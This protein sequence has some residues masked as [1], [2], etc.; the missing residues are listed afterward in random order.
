[1]EQQLA[2][3]YKISEAVIFADRLDKEY[4]VTNYVGELSFFEDLERPY[5]T[6]QVVCMDDF[7]VFDE[8]KLMGSEQIRFTV[9][10]VEESVA[11]LS[12]TIVL[13][14]VSII[15]TNKMT[16][17]TEVY[18]L[19][20]ISPHAYR[21]ANI[22]ISR[23]YTG[24]FEDTAQSILRNHLD[25][26]VDA[27]YIGA[28]SSLQK[29]ARVIIPY[30]SP[31]EA[32]EWLFKR[33]TTPIGSPFYAWCS[34]YD[35]VEGRDT[36]RFGNLETMVNAPAFNV[37]V[38]LIYSAASAASVAGKDLS[39]QNF[40][41][42]TINVENVQD[43]LKMVHEGAVGSSI[44]TVDTYT[45]DNSTR[46][47]S[48]KEHLKR[49]ETMRVIPYGANQNVYDDKQ[50]LTIASETKHPHEMDARQFSVITSYGTYGGINSYHDTEDASDDVNKLRGPAVHSM[51]NKNMFDI[52]IPGITFLLGLKEGNSGI[53]V[54][55]TVI[56]N[57]LSSNTDDDVGA[58][59]QYNNELS[60]KYLIH[61]VRNLFVGTKHECVVS[62]SK[63]ASNGVNF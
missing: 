63:I 20:L 12:F 29:P 9:E 39:R 54:G 48:I 6:A 4:N 10:S 55:D 7:G 25:V 49:L 32:V 3:E 8:I 31:L 44:N 53:S 13:N 62:I 60:G 26:D 1:M 56:I 58:G 33:A 57:Y 43:T 22:K 50:E 46:R 5:I 23:S 24:K 21:D 30:L 28:W 35:Q 61:K 18:H 15:L 2:Q 27:S 40:T 11:G 41:V 59:E 51:F 36:V 34:L 47:Y 37:E 19:N 38:P 17:R 16:D 14:I 45:S 52:V 42:K